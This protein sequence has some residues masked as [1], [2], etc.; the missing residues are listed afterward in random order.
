MITKL[1]NNMYISIKEYYQNNDCTIFYSPVVRKSVLECIDSCN[2]SIP[3][4]VNNNGLIDIHDLEEW[5]D[6]CINKP[7]VVI[8][9]Y[10]NEINSK[11]N[12]DQ[13]IKVTHL[14]NGVV[15][16]DC[17]GNKST[18]SSGDSEHV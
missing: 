6:V 12:I 3:L 2:N 1:D 18:I 9:H 4:K 10:N 11:Q 14:Y 8:N 16:F 7:F 5:L 13:I 15:Y 17:I